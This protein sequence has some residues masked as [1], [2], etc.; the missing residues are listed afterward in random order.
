MSCNQVDYPNSRRDF[1]CHTGGGC[2]ALAF[3]AMSGQSLI[4]GDASNP[5]ATKIHDGLGRAK[6]VIWLF[7]EG[8]PSHLDLFDRKPAVNELAG[9]SLP[10]SFPRPVTAMGEADSPILECKRKWA[11][12]GESGL[13]ISDWLPHHS[14]IADELCVIH[15]CVSDGINHAGGVCQM[16]TGAVFGGRPSLGSWVSYGLGEAN[17]NLPGFVVMKDSNSMVVNGARAWGA[18]FMPAT[19]QGVLLETGVEPIRNLNN[20]K[21]VSAAE[22][23][24]KLD[25]INQLNRRHYVGRESSSDLEARIRSYELAARMQTTAPDA[26]DIDQE[27]AHIRQMYGLD[28]QETEVYG[29]QCLLARRM[30]ER[31]VRFIQLYSGAGSKWDSHSNIEGNHSRL[32][33]GVDQPISALIT[34]LKQRGLLEDTLVI[35]GGEFGRTPMS[36]KGS[37]RDHNPT[38]FTMWMAGGGVKGGQTIG[39]TDE[40]GLYAVEDKLHVHDIHATTLALLGLDHTKVVYMNKGRPE[41]VDLNEGH[42]HTGIVSGA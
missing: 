14:S 21:N 33:R 3:A 15:S 19:Y 39:A 23:Q 13:W 35:W 34:D 1:L 11:Q 41:R 6:N 29:R 20:P 37:G 24:G 8:G 42:V 4:A 17:E 36:E 26:V 5:A 9:Q 25:F 16:N 27:P 32:C 31:G 12:H 22:Q 38:G 40:L 2:G 28:Q 30:V 7:M 18:G 10:E